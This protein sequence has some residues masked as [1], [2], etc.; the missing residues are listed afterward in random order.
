MVCQAS[1]T[2][3]PEVCRAPGRQKTI[4][5]PSCW[6]GL[7]CAQ[8]EASE[9]T[10]GTSLANIERECPVKELAIDR[11][12]WALCKA[13]GLVAEE[14]DMENRGLREQWTRVML[15]GADA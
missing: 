7:S 5:D 1:R 9:G 12:L 4:V 11:V 3:C 8:L 10:Q 15:Y 13:L 6:D 14:A 2:K